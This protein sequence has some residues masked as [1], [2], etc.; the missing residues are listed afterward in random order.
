MRIQGEK[1][2]EWMQR[3]SEIEHERK[4][5]NDKADDREWGKDIHTYRQ[6]LTCTNLQDEMKRRRDPGGGGRW[7]F[8]LGAMFACRED[9]AIR[10]QR[11]EV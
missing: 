1:K 8:M 10:R 6:E 2:R 3:V 7:G 11:K 5:G 4:R 9:H